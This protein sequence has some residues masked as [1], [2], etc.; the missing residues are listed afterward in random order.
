MWYTDPPQGRKFAICMLYSDGIPELRIGQWE[1]KLK[2]WWIGNDL[3]AIP[4]Q[5]VKC[6]HPIP[7]HED[8]DYRMFELII[9]EPLNMP[10]PTCG[11]E[12]FKPCLS[13]CS[14]A[15]AIAHL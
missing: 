4:Q 15:R 6:W 1:P 8:L 9:K 7:Y 2:K 11:A 10:C 14:N 5:I 12:A 13:I 3:N